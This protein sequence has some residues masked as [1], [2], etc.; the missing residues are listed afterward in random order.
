[1]CANHCVLFAHEKMR[2]IRHLMGKNRLLVAD[3]P[4]SHHSSHLPLCWV[5]NVGQHYISILTICNYGWMGG[6]GDGRKEECSIRNV[7][8]LSLL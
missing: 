1:M 4:I 7:I 5:V 2:L 3:G 6:C 8:E